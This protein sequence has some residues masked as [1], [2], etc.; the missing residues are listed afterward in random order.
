MMKQTLGWLQTQACHTR[1]GGYPDVFPF[2]TSSGF[3]LPCLPLP[4]GRQGQA[5]AGM[6]T[7]HLI[8]ENVIPV[9]TGIQKGLS[10][11]IILRIAQFS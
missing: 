7:Y 1:D 11:I 2:T 8:N 5:G 6:T 10:L 9:K 4:A 3:L